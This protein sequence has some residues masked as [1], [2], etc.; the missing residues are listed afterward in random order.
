MIKQKIYSR[1]LATT[2]LSTTVLFSNGVSADDSAR[3]AVTGSRLLQSDTNTSP[4]VTQIDGA[5]FRSLG[6]LRSEDLLNTLPQ[7]TPSQSS[8]IN[9]RATGTAQVDLRG[10]GAERT[11]VLVDGKRLPFGSF[12]APA[13]NLDFV[14]V[15]LIE[16]MDVTSGGGSAVYGSG[17]MAGVVN[18]IM[19]Q[20]FEGIE[21]DGQA[22]F[23][24]D[25]NNDNFANAVLSVNGITGPTSAGDGRNVGASILMGANTADGRGNVTAFFSYQDQ[26]EIRADQRDH[27]TCG[28][29][30][31]S[32]SP[33]SVGGIGCPQSGSFRRFVTPGLGVTIGDGNLFLSDNGTFVPFTGSPEQSFNFA[34]DT[35]QQRPIER[36]HMAA[37]SRYG[38][39]PDVEAYLDFSLLDNTTMSQAA[40]TAAFSTG[41]TVN[42]DNPF[43]TAPVSTGGNI[44]D[45]LG[46]SAADIASGNDAAFLLGYRNVEGT[47][48][49]TA[50][51]NTTWRVVGGFRGDLGDDWQWDAYG[52]FS[53]VSERRLERNLFVTARLQDALF[54]VS[55]GSGSVVCRSG[56]AGCAP[57]NVFQ[58]P[59]GQSQVTQAALNYIQGDASVNGDAEQKIVSGTLRGDLGGDGFISPLADRGMQLLVGVEWRE[60]QLTSRPDDQSTFGGPRTFTG[61]A[62]G[63][64][65]YA[66]ELRA[67]DLFMETEIPLVTG[68]QLIEALN[69]GGAYRYSDY[70]GESDNTRNGFDAH[71]FNA[72]A[73]WSISP[74][75]HLHGQFQRSHRVPN[76][77]EMFTDSDLISLSTISVNDPCA[78][79]FDPTT[80]TITEPIASAAQ[81]ANSGV[82]PAQ[83]GSIIEPSFAA[84][85]GIVGGNPALKSEISDS[86]FAGISLTPRAISNL[87]I[88]V[89]F[90]DIT[91]RNTIGTLSFSSILSECLDTGNSALCAVINRDDNGSLRSNSPDSQG[92]L[93][94]IRADNVNISRLS[95]RGLDFNASYGID[96]GSLGGLN[97]NY[98]ATVYFENSFDEIPSVRTLADCAGLYDGFNCDAPSPT[99]RHRLVTRWQSPWDVDVSA[100]WRR[101]SAINLDIGQ[102]IDNAFLSL[103]GNVLD[104]RLDA[105]NYLDLAA[106]W[107]VRKGV[108]LRVGVQNVLGRDPEL[109][110]E[111]FGNFGNFGNGNTFPG[112]YDPLG[113]YI[114]LGLTLSM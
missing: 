112:H 34:A 68:R 97:A 30:T 61:F 113:R 86:Y 20:D 12:Q 27:A 64:E 99:F 90:F 60:D 77:A 14:P 73:T 100:V 75:I 81:C 48:S 98:A 2:V 7:V 5:E 33:I 16:R 82:T 47:P 46:C 28:F 57:Y 85:N 79:D 21:F 67:L 37:F 15:Q 42:C 63:V 65:A 51:D 35:F 95:T 31:R 45:S 39:T 92:K 40:P 9:N 23:F 83:Y 111:G 36:F 43:L 96:I 66:G 71:S 70:S 84:V 62:G 25:S 109:T 10:L 106:D 104:D 89:E 3:H 4:S 69:I 54:A 110:T 24:Q 17:A 72:N 56:N 59:G 55:N 32:A 107:S 101:Q 11:L 52:Q 6:F 41:F 103:S 8:E 102:S 78:G 44:R 58:R 114:Y 22:G 53:R 94:G 50:F 29:N 26:N 88:A 105:A 49:Q 87:H 91:V 93:V 76:I 38:I 18:F 19:R 1:L 13:A 74:D 108:S 80:L